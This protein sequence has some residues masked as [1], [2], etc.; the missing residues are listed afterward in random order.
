MLNW[1]P[2]CRGHGS[3]FDMSA[4]LSYLTFSC[5]WWI[6]CCL[7]WRTSTCHRSV[8]TF[9]AFTL[10]VTTVTNAW[11][12]I[13][14]SF[15][16]CGCTRPQSRSDIQYR[17]A[18]ARRCV[19]SAPVASGPRRFLAREVQGPESSPR[20]N[21]FTAGVWTGTDLLSELTTKQRIHVHALI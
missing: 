20:R 17:P 16:R 15:P 14:S 9:A 12:T 11:S 4:L 21:L 1:L 6:P 8:P 3:T 10:G 18:Q 13:G 7:T 5:Q 19:R 2:N